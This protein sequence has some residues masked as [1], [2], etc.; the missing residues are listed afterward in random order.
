MNASPQPV[1]ADEIDEGTVGL[2]GDH[3]E[4]RAGMPQASVPPVIPPRPNVPQ[5]NMSQPVAPQVNMTAEE[6]DYDRTQ[7]LFGSRETTAVQ[8]PVNPAVQQRAV[9]PAPKAV[10]KP[11]P[12]EV[13]QTA[14][15]TAS[16]K[17]SGRISFVVKMAG[18]ALLLLVAFANLGM[19]LLFKS[20]AVGALS[21]LVTLANSFGLLLAGIG[22]IISGKKRKP[23]L[24]IGIFLILYTVL[25]IGNG[26]VGVIIATVN[27]PQILYVLYR[28]AGFLLALQ[29]YVIALGIDAFMRKK[30]PIGLAMIAAFLFGGLFSL[31]LGPYSTAFFPVGCII[32]SMIYCFLVRNE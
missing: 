29:P 22:F 8:T 27:G 25:L 4:S 9:H 20:A 13:R 28:L 23:D 26:F 32:I 24:F 16:Q 21:A 11:V 30:A 15:K 14:P 1:Q 19:V 5:N 6:S 2:F 7:S 18:F 17:S 3:R 31:F 10:P 12:Q